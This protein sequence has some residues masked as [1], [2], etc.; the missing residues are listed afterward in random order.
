MALDVMQIYQER[1]GQEKKGH[2]NNNPNIKDKDGDK[3]GK[4]DKEEGASFGQEGAEVKACF[5]CGAKDYKSC[6]YDNLKNVREKKQK[7][8][9]QKGSNHL[10][11]GTE[12]DVFF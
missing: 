4:A 7:L 6:P 2:K 1:S 12:D 10:S 8:R 3:D 5:K 11:I 9:E